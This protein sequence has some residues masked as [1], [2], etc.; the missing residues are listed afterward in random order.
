MARRKMR[1]YRQTDVV[2]LS[3]DHRVSLR[4]FQAQLV[5]LEQRRRAVEQQMKLYM[6]ET[7][8][9]DVEGQDWHF[10][11]TAGVA[12]RIPTAASTASVEGGQHDAAD[13]ASGA[14]TS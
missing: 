13:A 5:F 11:L 3:L 10:D 7:I 12:I 14:A 1:R 9:V 2:E 4:E 8:G 6:R